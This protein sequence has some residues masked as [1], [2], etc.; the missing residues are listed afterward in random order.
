MK[1]KTLF[2]CQNCGAQSV[3][4]LGKCPTCESWNSFVEESTSEAPVF[5]SVVFQRENPVLLSD[6]LIKQEERFKT[7]IG[8]FDRVLGGGVVPGSVV[9]IGGDPGI[10]KSTLSL[11]AAC[12]L[13]AQGH[14]VLYVSGEE[15]VKQTKMRAD[16]LTAKGKDHLFIVNQIDLNVII[17]H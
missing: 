16:R 9:L 4:W 14:T 2:I 1:T 6:V 12:S 10:G 3:A 17:G 15:S 13:S 8:E 11:Q 5:K 7:G